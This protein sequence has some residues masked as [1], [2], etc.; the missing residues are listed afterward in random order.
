MNRIFPLRFNLS[1]KWR[2]EQ[3]VPQLVSLRVSWSLSV[4]WEGCCAPACNWARFLIAVVVVGGA[5]GE[6]HHPAAM[7]WEAGSQG[8]SWSIPQGPWGP[9]N[10]HLFLLMLHTW[11]SQCCRH[12]PLQPSTHIQPSLPLPHL[13]PRLQDPDLH[14]S[15]LLTLYSSQRTSLYVS[16]SIGSTLSTLRLTLASLI[17]ST[18]HGW[19][20]KDNWAQEPASLWVTLGLNDN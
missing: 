3:E 6:A 11:G 12:R 9:A 1:K 4:R 5:A 2:R 10:C 20:F 13:L 7:S 18:L 17:T 8:R 19:I 14:S 15:A 16:W